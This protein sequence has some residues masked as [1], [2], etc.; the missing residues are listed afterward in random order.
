MFDSINAITVNGWGSL[1]KACIPTSWS[2]FVVDV[3]FFV[4]YPLAVMF[5]LV[6]FFKKRIRPGAQGAWRACGEAWSKCFWLSMILMVLGYF[7]AKEVLTTDVCGMVPYVQDYRETLPGYDKSR[8]SFE[9]EEI[10][11]ESVRNK[12]S[13]YKS[14]DPYVPSE[15]KVVRFFYRHYGYIHPFFFTLIDMIFLGCFF[16]PGFRMKKQGIKF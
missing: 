3:M 6:L 5:L 1:L 15:L 10:I 13:S 9:N 12:S 11:A 7:G 14:T 2:L 16:W 8:K 4:V